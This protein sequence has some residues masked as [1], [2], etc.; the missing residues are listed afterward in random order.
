M[1]TVWMMLLK[2][3]QEVVMDLIPTDTDGDGVVD[4]LDIDSDNDGILDNVEAQ[5][6]DSF[7]EPCDID[8]DGNGLDDH[9]ESAPGAGEGLTPSIQMEIVTRISGISTRTTMGFSTI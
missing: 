6:S 7:M 5:P 3:L 8:S 2:K 1:G 9:Y 4:Y